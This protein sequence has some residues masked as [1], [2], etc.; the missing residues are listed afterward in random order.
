MSFWLDTL[1]A[2]ELKLLTE[3]GAA[4]HSRA[5]ERAQGVLTYVYVYSGPFVKTKASS[6]S[7][8]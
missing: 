4:L 5:S 8:T 2:A 7:W 1:E 6:P 3:R